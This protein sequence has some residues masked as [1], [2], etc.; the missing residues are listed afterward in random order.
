M[1][2]TLYCAS[3]PVCWKV[4]AYLLET[5][6]TLYV[7][8]TLYIFLKS[9]IPLWNYDRQIGYESVHRHNS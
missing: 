1:Y 3:L 2:N 5:L 9:P 7:T 8:I 6:L 4:F